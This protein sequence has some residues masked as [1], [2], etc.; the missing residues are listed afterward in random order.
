MSN[1]PISIT[2]ADYNLMAKAYI[3]GHGATLKHICPK[4]LI[5]ETHI[6]HEELGLYFAKDPRCYSGPEK[7]KHDNEAGLSCETLVVIEDQPTM[8][9]ENGSKEK[10]T[11]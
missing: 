10:V 6:T 5:E 11:C 3:N 9:K 8:E 2:L 7:T 4:G 1:R